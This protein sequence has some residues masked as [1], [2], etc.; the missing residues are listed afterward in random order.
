V[1]DVGAAMVRQV[2]R[3]LAAGTLCDR[4]GRF[5]Y[6]AALRGTAVPVLGI[7][8]E[9]DAVCSPDAAREGIEALDPACRA[10]LALGPD[11]GHLDPLHGPEAPAV[12]APRVLEWLDAHRRD[13][14]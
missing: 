12:V 7:A 4:D 9:G 14:W 1:E 8:A 5:D 3:W 10:W 13:C 2:A 11:W 6:V